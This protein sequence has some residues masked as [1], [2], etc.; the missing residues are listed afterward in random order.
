MWKKSEV[1]GEGHVHLKLVARA[2]WVNSTCLV[3][4]MTGY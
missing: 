2:C 3:G 1:M 4:L